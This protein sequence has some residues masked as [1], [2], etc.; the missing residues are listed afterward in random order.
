MQYAVTLDFV[1][2]DPTPTEDQ[3]DAMVDALAPMGAAVAGGPGHHRMSITLTIDGGSPLSAI[4]EALDW[5]GKVARAAGFKSELSLAGGEVLTTDEQ[6]LRLA[7]PTLPELVGAAD[8]AE[9]LHV[10]RQRVHQLSTE[11]PRFPKPVSH[12]KMGPLWTRA[13]IEAFERAWERKPGRPSR[14]YNIT[15]GAEGVSAEAL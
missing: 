4:G 10:S 9:L 13:S 8:A 1:D 5:V 7:E 3:I 2:I 11:N 15:E 12:V 14:H 6:D